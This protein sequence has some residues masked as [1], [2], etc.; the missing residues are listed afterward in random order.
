M[1]VETITSALRSVAPP[2]VLRFAPVAVVHLTALG[3]LATTEV[4]TVGRGLFLLAW[5]VLN[6]ALI[7]LLR[8]PLAAGV[9]ALG[10][11]LAVVAISRFKFEITWM[12][13]TFLDVLI[14]DRDSIA[15]LLGRFPDLRTWLAIG[16][17]VAVPCLALLWWFDP[18]RVRPRAAAMAGLIG[19]VGLAGLSRAVPEQPWEPF[20]GNNHVSNFARSSVLTVSELMTKGWIEFDSARAAPFHGLGEEPCTPAKKPPHIILVLDESSFDITG[21]PGIKVPPGY[22][23]HFRSMDGETRTLITEATGGPTWYTEYNVLTGLSARSFGRLMFYVTRIA[24][25]RVERGLPQALRHCGYKTFSLYPAYGAF[26]SA[27][28]FQSSAGV[29]RLIDAGEM[30]ARDVEPDQFYYNKA[31]RLIGQHRASAPLF[32][33]VYTVANHFPWTD[34]YRPDLTPDWRPLGNEPQVDEYIRRQTMSAKDYKAFVARL[35]HE[36]PD[37]SFLIV[38]FGDH[39]PSIAHRLIEP[40]LPDEEIARR[41]MNLDPRYY[42]TYYAIDAVN[43]RPAD[44][45]P[46]RT[47]LDAAYLPLVVLEAAGVPLDPSFL[48]QKRILERCNGQFYL[49]A[50]GA[51]ARRFNRLLIEAGLIKGLA[52]R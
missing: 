5:I 25:G 16:G 27:R 52:A 40:G 39:P 14:I 41:V 37:E 29:Q 18:L 21:V 35:E 12:T 10:L 51:E 50:G 26:L 32:L 9:L 30:G 7:L 22:D 24:A 49:C 38:R 45:P 6:C 33:F 13:I 4:D 1:R 15:F 47:P 3:V 17:L 31:A 36:F 28:G 34:V 8:R 42:T 23:R 2:R 19:L 46:A 48:E 20:Q 44:L 43:F 11:M